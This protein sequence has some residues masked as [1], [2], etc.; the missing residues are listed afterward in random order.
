MYRSQNTSYYVRIK[1]T[2]QKVLDSFK[3]LINI[4]HVD[5]LLERNG[6]TSYVHT[7]KLNY[8][9]RLVVFYTPVYIFSVQMHNFPLQIRQGG[10]VIYLL[11]EKVLFTSAYIRRQG[12]YYLLRLSNW[13]IIWLV[14]AFLQKCNFLLAIS[15]NYNYF[16]VHYYIEHKYLV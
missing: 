7:Y 3:H 10:H 6:F 14:D 8:M 4:G 1:S 5:R 16:A 11:V 13:F 2:M 15:T 12:R 9:A